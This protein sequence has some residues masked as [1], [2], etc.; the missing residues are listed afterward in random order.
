MYAYKSVDMDMYILY[1]YIPALNLPHVRA[2][3]PSKLENICEYTLLFMYMEVNI[4]LH[5]HICIYICIPAPHLPH[6]RAKQPSKS[7]N[8]ALQMGL[9]QQRLKIVSTISIRVISAVRYLYVY[10]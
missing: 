10:L 6:V 3:Q 9:G 8:V 4:C 5:M 7:A 2:K 1:A